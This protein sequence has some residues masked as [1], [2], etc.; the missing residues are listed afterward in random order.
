[1]I[2]T[3]PCVEFDA[4]VTFNLNFGGF[5]VFVFASLIADGIPSSRP[6]FRLGVV[7]SEFKEREARAAAPRPLSFS[8]GGDGE[9]VGFSLEVP[10]VPGADGRDFKILSVVAVEF[11]C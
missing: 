4:R 6:L 10:F 1:L 9:I 5:D 3:V 2:L 8:L 7:S 11:P